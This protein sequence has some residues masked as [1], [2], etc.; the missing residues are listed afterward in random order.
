MSGAYCTVSGL[1]NSFRDWAVEWVI[2]AGW[3]VTLRYPNKQTIRQVINLP[4]QV[5]VKDSRHGGSLQTP[6]M[7]LRNRNRKTIIDGPVTTGFELIDSTSVKL[8]SGT[9]SYNTFSNTSFSAIAAAVGARHGVSI[10]G[11]PGDPVWKEDLKQTDG[12]APLQRMAAAA[13]ME[14]LV[15]ESGVVE[16]VPLDA[17]GSSA[18]DPQEID[19]SY[20]PHDQFGK[21]FVQKQ[22]GLGTYGGPQYYDFEESG[23]KTGALSSPL[24][25]PAAADQ[26]AQGS[27]GWVGFWDGPPNGSG[28]LISLHSMNGESAD[29]LTVPLNGVQPATHYSCNVYPSKVNQTLPV[30]ARLRVVGSSPV[31]IPAG[32]DPA[33]SVVLVSNNGATRGFTS[34]WNEPLLP[35]KAYVQAKAA[36]YFAAL[37]RGTDIQTARGPLDHTVRLRQ[38]WGWDGFSGRIV[39]IRH[40]GGPAQMP[41]TEITVEAT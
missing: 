34:T 28:R 18:F 1:P 14:I 26:S 24:N 5:T 13:G 19:E 33:F 30:E 16:F 4:S 35:S 6:Q 20:S 15:S 21:L 12:W 10:V 38:A 32:I 29:A 31:T 40:S 9:E 22:S 36:A 2:N 39:A 3:N 17:G 25:A 8:S 27:V 7:W 41:I 37:N 23:Y 11:V